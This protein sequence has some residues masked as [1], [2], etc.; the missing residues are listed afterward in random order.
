MYRGPLSLHAPV[1]G[2]FGGVFVLAIV[3][4]AS[5]K[6]GMNVSFQIVMFSR[7]EPRSGVAESLG[8]S[9]YIFQEFPCCFPSWLHPCAPPLRV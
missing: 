8:S 7:S 4:S 5:L 9:V 2:H 6:P 3:N 1:A